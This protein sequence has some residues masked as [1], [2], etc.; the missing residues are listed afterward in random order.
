M[1]LLRERPEGFRGAVASAGDELGVS[2]VG[3]GWPPFGRILA[4]VE[5]YADLL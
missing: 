5:Q 3:R 1:T 4:R 2:A